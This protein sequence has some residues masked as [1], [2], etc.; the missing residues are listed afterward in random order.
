M[1]ETIEIK[2]KLK[3]SG[4]DFLT[5]IQ[6]HEVL[7]SII[8]QIQ[9]ANVMREFDFDGTIGYEVEHLKTDNEYYVLHYD[10]ETTEYLNPIV[11]SNYKDALDK[12]K[13]ERFYNSNDRIELIYSPIDGENRVLKS[14]GAKL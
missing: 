9:E 11:F 13:L 3:I 4:W 2:W 10:V 1:K 5:D 12:Y 8:R 7:E 6:R 14:K